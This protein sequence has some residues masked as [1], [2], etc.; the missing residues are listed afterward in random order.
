[1]MKKDKKYDV[2]PF[3]KWAGGKRQILNRIFKYIQ[4]SIQEDESPYENN[5]CYIEPFLGGGAVFFNLQPKKAIINDLNADLINAYKIIK[6]DK[7]LKL[8]AILNE[9]KKK[10]ENEENREEYYY[11]IRHWDREDGW[12]DNKTDVERAGRMIF[13]NKTCYNGLYR[14]N[15]KGQFNTPI[16]RYKNPLICDEDNLKEIHRYFKEN[17]DIEIMCGSYENAISKAKA[18]DVIYIDPPYDYKD[19]DGFTKYQM[20]GFTF[21]DFKKL[22]EE[23]DKALEKEAYIII[24]NNA[25]DK[26]INLFQQDVKYKVFYDPECFDSLRTISCIGESRKSGKEVIIWGIPNRIPLPQ[27]NNVDKIICLLSL[28]NEDLKNKDKLKEVIHVDTVRQVSYYLSALSFLNYINN[29]HIFT[30]SALKIKS[31]SESEIS[32]SV[33]NDILNKSL[34]KKL[35]N[36]YKDSEIKKEDIVAELKLEYKDLSPS[37]LNRRAGTIEKWLKWATDILNNKSGKECI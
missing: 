28:T 14:V 27:A 8:I 26:V 1:M 20:E 29:K 3:V 7:V 31:L 17:Q 13:I 34:F 16:G 4:N 35:F 24:S 25:T 19:D 18:G 30:D 5:Y 10:Y 6:S 33:A 9:H 2:K 11:D 23:C 22:K 15:N 12:P 32:K 37:T 36:K 21:D